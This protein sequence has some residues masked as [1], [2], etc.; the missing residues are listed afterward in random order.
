MTGKYII[1]FISVLVFCLFARFF[2][3]FSELRSFRDGEK[4]QFRVL[5]LSDPKR[6]GKFQRLS[7]TPTGREKVFITAPLYPSFYYGQRLS[8]TGVVKKSKIGGLSDKN[9]ST[10]KQILLRGENVINTMYFPSIEA[11]KEVVLL[12]F[13]ILR[14]NLITIFSSTLNPV[15]ESLMLGI[16][17]GIRGT[18]P[19]EL[20]DNL[21]ATGVLHITAA[22]GMNVTMVA[23]MVFFLLAGFFRRQV[24]IVIGCVFVWGYAVLAGL[25]P[26]I[27]RASVMSTFAFSAGLLGRQNTGLLT[28]FFTALVLLFVN[29][30]LYDDV[31]FLLSCTS[32]FGIIAMSQIVGV[33]HSFIDPLQ[34][35]EAG[36]FLSLFWQDVQTTIAAQLGSLPLLFLYFG[37]Y[38][39]LSVVVNALILWSIPIVMLLGA[40]GAALG[41]IYQPLSVPVLYLA[42]PLLSYIEY[43]VTFFA[44]IPINIAVDELSLFFVIGYY[45]LVCSIYL[46]LRSKR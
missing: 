25:E 15:S 16:V 23:G 17:F 18:M 19:K 11:E 5:L 2:F 27:L 13:A 46:F 6:E 14:K 32:T 21:R 3:Y 8:V 33:G 1:V 26:S 4:V 42:M 39:V 44:K 24:A 35:K 29:P 36:S 37:Q 38:N 9:R 45:C 31:G 7:V 20:A 28:L 41:L 43:V 34:K 30:E 10:P 40:L 22:S 12:P